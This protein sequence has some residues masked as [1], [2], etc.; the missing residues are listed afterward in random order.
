MFRLLMIVTGLVFTGC[1]QE[2]IKNQRSNV[3]EA[4]SMGAEGVDAEAYRGRRGRGRKR[5]GR[6]GGRSPGVSTGPVHHYGT[7]ATKPGYEHTVELKVRHSNKCLTVLHGNVYVGAPVV[8][9]DCNSHDPKMLWDVKSNRNSGT[10]K[11]H[12]R[13]DGNLCMGLNGK[14]LRE[15]LVLKFCNGQDFSRS[16][17]V[18]PANGG[19]EILQSQYSNNCL[20]IIDWS[21][22]YGASVINWECH[23]GDN[24]KFDLINR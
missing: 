23:H 5:G 14:G 19:G 12:L 22:D 9:A 8:Q 7:G 17:F 24:Q 6:R 20:D 18:R 3:E 1:G 21:Q 10:Y 2:S 15:Q 4:F 13:A 16:F 11:F